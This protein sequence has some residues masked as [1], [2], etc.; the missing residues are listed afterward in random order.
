MRLDY[1]VT[2]APARLF[3]GPGQRQAIGRAARDLGRKVLICT[4][5]RLARLPILQE[6]LEDITVHNGLEATVFDATEPEL[7]LAGILDCVAEYRSFDPD[8]IV[9][10]GGGSCL[11]LA[12]LV[13]LLLSYEGPL[14]QYYGEFKVPGPV[15][16]LIAVPTTSGTGSEVTPVAV[17][18]DPERTMKVGISSPALIPHTAICDPE[19]T[20]TCPPGL[21]AIS[22]A[23]ALAHAVEAFAAV[24]R[25]P[26]PRMAMERVFVGKN[27]LSDHYALLAIK[28]IFES[29]RR[30][31]ADGGDI[32]AR[33]AV[34]L[35]ATYAG[36][37]FGSGGT[38]IAHAIQY[39]VGAQTHTAH[40]LGVGILL[41]Y[42]MDFNMQAASASYAE[43][44][45]V[46]GAASADQP[47]EEAG[48]AAIAAVRKLFGDIGIPASLRNI[49]L[50]EDDLDSLSVLSMNAARLVEN[51][52]AAV[53]PESI[54]QIL[55]RAL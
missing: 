11:D 53:D 15:R 39:P 22:G 10:L 18:A 55:M 9:G 54:K 16:P 1:G 5:E 3:F 40:G 30:A 33:S 49:A 47:D 37:A 51:N 34:M 31:V 52:P 17:L 20:V 48:R 26:D 45:R 43:V 8:V 24:S 35:G 23:D 2:R 6:I 32:E 27:T 19:L 42:T 41:P 50:T 25:P 14:S 46:I 38:A 7:P 4:D 28:L 29:L 13:S 12:K 21:T 44:G 36:L